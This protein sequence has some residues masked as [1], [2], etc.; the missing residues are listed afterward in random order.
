MHNFCAVDMSSLYPG[1]IK[2]R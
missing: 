1:V 2:D